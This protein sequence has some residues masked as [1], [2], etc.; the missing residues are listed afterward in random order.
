M[1][2]WILGALVA[3]SGCGTGGSLAPGDD[4]GRPGS[5]ARDAQ[6]DVEVWDGAGPFDSGEPA[7]EA[8]PDAGA[9]LGADAA[10]PDAS[11]P[12]AAVPDAAV[13][14]AAVPD[15]AVPDASWP[16]AA[17][18]DAS[19]PD[20]S[21]PGC[22]GGGCA[23]AVTR[24]RL[25]MQ[26]D[27]NEYIRPIVVGFDHDPAESVFG[28][29]ADYEDRNVPYCYDGHKGSD[30]L[31]E[32]GFETM[33]NGSAEVYAA[34]DGVVTLVHDGEYDRCRAVGLEVQCPGYA[35]IPPANRVEI[36]HADG[37]VT[38]YLHLKKWSILVE[39]GDYVTCGQL[40][41]LVGSSGHSSTPHLHFAVRGVDG[42]QYDPFAG[43]LS[44]PASSW[45]EQDGPNG[46]PAPVCQGGL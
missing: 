41:A 10:V 34:A 22:D 23:S 6:T 33:D 24:F 3:L 40:L 15:A 28:L 18:P 36:L 4:A 25:P 19:V 5:L 35:E 38:R 44:Q 32:G 30:F 26:N 2:L 7:P 31:L 17:V 8:R 11:V 39:Q 27:N 14:D 42:V 21:T 46:F 37:Q 16:D 1:S 13:P 12:D 20:A 29:C 43:P 45:V 9:V